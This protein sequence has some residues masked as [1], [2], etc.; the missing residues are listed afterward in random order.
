VKIASEELEVSEMGRIAR[1]WQM[2]KMSLRVIRKDKEILLFPILSGMF[3]IML[4]ASFVTGIFFTSDFD[5]KEATNS[6]TV[7]G[8]MAVFYFASFFITFFFNAAVI[9]CATIRLDGGNPTFSDGL[10]IAAQNVGR[11]FL[12]ALVAA[13]VGFIIRALQKKVGFLGRFILGA[14]GIAWTVVTYFVVPVLIYEK[15]GPWAAIKRSASILRKTWGEALV[16]NLGL[17]AV[18]VLLG[19]LGIVFIVAGALI[20]GLTGLVVAMIAAIVYWVILGIVY[21][22]AESVL[23]AALYRYATTG[24]VTEYIKEVPYGNPWTR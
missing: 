16:G 13:T 2:T 23:V 18:F 24:K 10:R 6:W 1:G 15:I 14:I 5:V 3:T 21:S 9:G 8:L 20:G 11:I 22:A 19:L 7:W 12:W 17:G 4:L